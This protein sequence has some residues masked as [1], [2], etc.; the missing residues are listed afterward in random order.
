MP[1]SLFAPQREGGIGITMRQLKETV[2]TA[3]VGYV[4]RSQVLDN[5][6]NEWVTLH[7]ADDISLH[8]LNKPLPAESM[9]GRLHRIRDIVRGDP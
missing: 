9:L 2:W 4:T 7:E 8:A 1:A 5:L 3:Q 6:E